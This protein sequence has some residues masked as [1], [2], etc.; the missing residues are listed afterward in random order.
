MV[1]GHSRGS[2]RWPRSN[3]CLVL[4]RQRHTQ[5]SLRHQPLCYYSDGVSTNWR[6]VLNSCLWLQESKCES[7]AA[8][9]QDTGQ[10]ADEADQQPRPRKGKEQVEAAIT[11]LAEEQQRAGG[12]AVSAQPGASDKAK[13]PQPRKLLQSS[14]R[15]LRGMRKDTAATTLNEQLLPILWA[16]HVVRHWDPDLPH[17]SHDLTLDVHLGSGTLTPACGE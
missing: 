2:D 15:H 10:A 7:A 9:R 1:G 5:L 4:Q 14:T 3:S 16:Q 12:S 13:T 6:N 17:L 8:G 11:C